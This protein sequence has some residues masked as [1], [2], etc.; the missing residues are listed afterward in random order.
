M[1]ARLSWRAMRFVRD[2]SG[3]ATIE[4]LLWL[5]VFFG[6]LILASDA[7]L[8]F[9]GK[10]QALRIMQNGNRAFAL[11]RLA[12]TAATESWIETQFD[13]LSPN[14]AATT[15][16]NNGLVST[17]MAIPASEL[18]LFQ[19]LNVARGWT[20]TVRSQHFIE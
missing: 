14:A 4:S 20:I 2:E 17:T 19:S 1:R 3:S 8:A 18:V 13:A 9:Y 11:G 6:L 12:T 7:S 15:T 16:V 5:T 10:A